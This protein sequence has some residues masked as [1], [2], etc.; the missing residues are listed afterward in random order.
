MLTGFSR[1]Y[2]TDAPKHP[3]GPSAPDRRRTCRPRTALSSRGLGRNRRPVEAE[4]VPVGKRSPRS[5]WTSAEIRSRLRSGETRTG[6]GSCGSRPTTTPPGRPADR[7]C[8]W[9]WHQPCIGTAR[10]EKTTA[11]QRFPLG[12]STLLPL[13]SAP[14]TQGC[15]QHQLGGILAMRPNALTQGPTSTPHSRATD[16]P[17]D[18]RPQ[19]PAVNNADA[20]ASRVGCCGVGGRLDLVEDGVQPMVTWRARGS[21]GGGSA[22]WR[23]AGGSP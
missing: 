9:C 17:W 6:F 4:G 11:F 22:W 19:G 2:R 1:A 5:S 15:R 16:V 20:A 10:R 13:M 7:R 21:P 14:W 23:S 12:S 18:G 8:P 3:A